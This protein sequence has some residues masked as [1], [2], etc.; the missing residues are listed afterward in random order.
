MTEGEQRRQERRAAWADTYT[1]I[2]LREGW[3]SPE[4]A[5][6]WRADCAA[7]FDRAFPPQTEESV[8]RDYTAL[9]GGPK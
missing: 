1:E 8:K 3:L 9:T 7:R 6:Q 2:A 5:G 4:G